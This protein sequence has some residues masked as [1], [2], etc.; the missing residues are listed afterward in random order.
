MPHRA[1]PIFEEF[2]D[3]L[4]SA[5]RVRRQTLGIKERLESMEM[6]IAVMEEV[7]SAPLLT[8]SSPSSLAAPGQDHALSQ[9]PQSP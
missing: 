2:A 3:D 8:S 4:G 7:I 9:A 1:T 6:R 5:L